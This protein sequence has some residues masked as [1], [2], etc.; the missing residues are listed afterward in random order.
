LQLVDQ[1][2]DISMYCLK[3]GS[4]SPGYNQLRQQVFHVN[5]MVIEYFL[6]DIEQVKQL[7]IPHRVID[8]LTVFSS[9][10]NIAGPE[11]SQLL[12]EIAL[13]DV[14]TRAKIIYA[15]FAFAEFVQDSDAQRVCKGLEEFGFELADFSHVE[16]AAYPTQSSR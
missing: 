16:H 5:Q 3:N 2:E 13:L 12:G 11:D 9:C 8:V 7:R 15:H 14:Q 10:E 6:G 1:H 4:P